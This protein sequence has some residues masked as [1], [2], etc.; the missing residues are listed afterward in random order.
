[1]NIT[2]FAI[3]RKRITFVSMLVILVTGL[4]T[5]F[6]MPRAEDPGFI[7]RTASAGQRPRRL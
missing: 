6:N 5:Y 2:Q 7:I 1:M 3:E 4:S